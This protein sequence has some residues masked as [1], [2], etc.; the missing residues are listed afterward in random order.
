MTKRCSRLSLLWLFL[1]PVL[2]CLLIASESLSDDRL[3]QA[4]RLVS[5]EKYQEARDLLEQILGPLNKSAPVIAYYHLTFCYVQLAEWKKAED[6]LGKLSQIAPQ[7]LPSIYL[8]AYLLFRTGKYAES[9]RLITTYL[10][11]DPASDAARKLLGLNQ[12]MLGMLD[13]AEAELKHV[14]QPG[15]QDWEAYYFLGQ[16]YF[17]KNSF[18]P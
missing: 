10:E 18:L 13:A 14:T 7:A 2:V 5:K 17:T 4:V 8:R 6:T 11:K 3:G 9:L 15:S 16:I 1:S 12:F